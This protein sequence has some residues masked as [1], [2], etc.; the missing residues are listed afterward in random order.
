MAS[1]Q[2]QLLSHATLETVCELLTIQILSN[3]NH[4]AAPF[5][6]RFPGPL[7]GV[8]KEHVDRLEDKFL[9]HALYSQN[10]LAP[11]KVDSLLLQES[12]NPIVKLLLDDLTGHVN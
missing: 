2:L 1:C 3:E 4:L 11:E 5:L 8:G 12:G 10:A 9:L 6:A 7:H